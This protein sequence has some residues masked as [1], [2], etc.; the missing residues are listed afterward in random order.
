MRAQYPVIEWRKIAGL[1]DVIA[2][3]YFNLD[4]QIIWDV[5]KNKLPDL[6]L[7]VKAILDEPDHPS[8]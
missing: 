2:H 4:L 3:G 6:I 8:D 1:R 5:V 7:Q